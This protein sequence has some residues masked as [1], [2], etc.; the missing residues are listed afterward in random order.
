MKFNA[1]ENNS[2]LSRIPNLAFRMLVFLIHTS[3]SPHGAELSKYCWNSYQFL[4]Y[5]KFEEVVSNYCHFNIS[6]TG[7]NACGYTIMQLP[8]TTKLNLA[9]HVF[10]LTCISK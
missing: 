1:K 10:K 3:S 9:N 2:N 6:N 7:K 8:P 4:Y 5:L